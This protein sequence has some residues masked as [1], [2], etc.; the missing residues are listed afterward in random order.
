MRS[1]HPE[2]VDQVDVTA[3][4]L[5]DRREPVRGH[6]WVVV[7]M[8]STLD[9]ATAITGRSG[10]IGGSGD[11]EAFHALRSSA[12]VILAGAGT[13]RAE[14]YGPVRVPPEHVAH[15]R[16]A[17]RTG[18]A[19]L[20]SISRSC[21]F[22][23]EARI[24]SDP[25][26]RPLIYTVTE[27]PADRVEA[28]AGVA[29]IVMVGDTDV[30]LHAVMADLTAREV[31]CVLCEGGPMLNG[32]LIDADLVDEWCW[33]IGPLLAAGPSARTAHGTAETP[34][35]EFLLDRLL[36]DGRDLL[37]RYVASADRST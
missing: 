33:T 36:G 18:P 27:A 5:A 3:T 37:A 21:A 31:R 7:N 11:H 14:N 24:F 20:A 26:Q 8:A 13:I 12:D 23:P 17:G 25:G 29:E 10:G 15:R 4:Y 6:P 28:L 9:G 2:P 35:R 19:R 1:L 22:D 16:A 34:P 30:D 32:Q